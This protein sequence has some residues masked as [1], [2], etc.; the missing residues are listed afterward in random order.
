M[1]QFKHLLILLTIVVF[2]PSC[3]TFKAIKMVNGGEVV[4]NSHSES[5]VPF[6]LEGHPILIKARLNNS[7][8]EYV[9][10][11]DTGALTI[12]R[13]EVAKELNL[14]KGIEIEGN[15]SA[16]KSKSIDLVKLE[17]VIVG[18]ME[19]RDCAAGVTDFSGMFAPRIAGILGSN[20][21]RHFKVTIDYRKKEI[22]LSQEKKQTTVQT[23][24]SIIP[25]EADMKM[26][27]APVIECVVDGKIEGTAIVDT[28]FP[29]I[30]S[31]PLAMIKKTNSFK[32]GNAI[33]SKGSMTFGL[34]GGKDKDYGVRIDAFKVGDIKLKNIPSSSNSLK[35]G[36]ILLGN[37][38][39][40]NFLVTL[41]Y[42]MKEMILTPYGTPFE[43]NIPTYGLALAKE[44]NKTIV[45]GIWDNSSASSSGIN[46]GDEVEKVNSMEVNTLSL[47]ELGSIFLDKSISILEIEYSNDKGIQKAILHKG[48]LLPVLK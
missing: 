31:L 38:F 21:F 5:V 6:A 18:N 22:I 34:F 1:N 26:G 3:T 48:V 39:L 14:A 12:I 32:A 24:A 17:K 40:E 10:I 9:F 19:V 42:P 25:F 16:G 7:Q 27:F 36:H 44:R 4:P 47:M 37:K 46:L 43:T 20:F 35:A 45:S 33:A 11:F 30:V 28:G 8:K 23:N 13:Q 41:N 2:M 29:G 15:D